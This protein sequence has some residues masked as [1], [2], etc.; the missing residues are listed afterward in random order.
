MVQLYILNVENLKDPLGHLEVL[1]GLSKERQEKILRYKQEH[2]RKQGLGA[3]L[4]LKH[5]LNAHGLSMDNITYG[6]NGKPQIEGLHFNLSHSG[7]VV[8]C[9]VSDKEVGCDIEKISDVKEGIADRFFT[10]KEVGYLN[11]FSIIEKQQEFFR[12]WT[13]KESYMK[14][15]GEGMSLP[16]SGFEVIIGEGIQIYREGQ[17]CPCVIKEYEIEGYKLA[18]CALEEE[19]EEVIFI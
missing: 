4:L 12:L 1:E 8:I 19:F 15:T 3:A 7:D 18:V 13:I 17:L 10:E 11:S 14:L 2:S 16:L 9:A 6:K 5:V